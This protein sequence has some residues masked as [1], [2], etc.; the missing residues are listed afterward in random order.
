MVQSGSRAA[1]ATLDLCRRT[2]IE[3]R[4]K[5]KVAEVGSIS[6]KRRWR[7]R[8]CPAVGGVVKRALGR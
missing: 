1:C 5:S 7:C 3:L 2:E 6:G 8:Q 4:H